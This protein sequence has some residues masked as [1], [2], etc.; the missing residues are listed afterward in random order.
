MQFSPGIYEHAAALIGERPWTVSRDAELLYRA[1]RAA[2]ER[3]RHPIL[4]AGIDVYNVEPEALGAELAEPDGNGMPAVVAPLCPSIADLASIAPPDPAKDG[5]MP[6]VLEAARRLRSELSG[7]EVFVPICGPLAFANSLAGIEETLCSLVEDPEAMTAALMHLVEIQEPYLQAIIAAGARP[8]IFESGASPPF[9][10]P[11]L[12][13]EI[14]APALGRLFTL[15]RP[16]GPPVCIL[17]GNVT[18]VLPELLKLA[19]G[20]LICPA[21]TNQS[22]FVRLAAAY[23]ETH[24]RVNMRPDILLETDF[25]VIAA[26][27]SRLL[28][29]AGTHPNSSFGCGV[30]PYETDPDQ[31]LRLRDWVKTRRGMSD[32]G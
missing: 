8:L 5:R 30:V 9:V 15:C 31:L 7:A 26:E 28:A 10:P 23:P 4:V 12:F 20:F 3:Y 1:Q 24:V 16:S 11:R 29:L 2:W 6:L 22:E 21:E 19:P 13:A 18:P 32:E 14:E 27:A 17:G 25:D